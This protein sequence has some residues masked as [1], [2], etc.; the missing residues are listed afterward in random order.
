[1]NNNTGREA[2]SVE[3]VAWIVL[4]EDRVPIMCAPAKQMCNDH[5]NEAI[6]DFDI[7]EAAKWVIREAFTHPAPPDPWREDA[8]G[9]PHYTTEQLQAYGK[10]CAAAER[11]RIL[12][13]VYEQS[14]P[15]GTP[16]ECIWI[17]V[18]S[19]VR[20]VPKTDWSAA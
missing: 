5:I 15:F 11:E 3:P 6:N 18:K 2:Q 20:H 17:A 19:Q 8:D 7:A 10:V 12:Q 1:M 14:T 9:K 4:D 13:I 16:G